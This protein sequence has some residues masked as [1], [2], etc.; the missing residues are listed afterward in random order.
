[1]AEVKSI[2][3]LH[4]GIEFKYTVCPEANGVG[5]YRLEPQEQLATGV[6]LKEA[7]KAWLE[8]YDDIDNL[9]V[10]MELW[11]IETGV[12]AELQEGDAATITAKFDEFIESLSGEE[13]FELMATENEIYIDWSVIPVCLE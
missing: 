9:V 10:N 8:S 1:M 4:K 5:I 6:T 13:L 12:T 2:I 3:V 11:A 7:C